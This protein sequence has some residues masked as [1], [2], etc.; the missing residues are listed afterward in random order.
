[1]PTPPKK[2][3]SKDKF[4]SR[5]ISYIVKKEGKPQKQAIAI[6]NSMWRRRKMNENEDNEEYKEFT[7]ICPITTYHAVKPIKQENNED[8]KKVIYKESDETRHAVA[9][10]GDRFY[11]GKFL[12]AKELEKVYPKWKG[13]LHDINHMGTTHLMGLGVVSDIR[14]FVGYQKNVTYD[15]KTKKV[16][17]DIKGNEKTLYGKAWRGYVNLCEEAGKIPNVSIA[18]QGKLGTMKAKDLPED[19]NYSD[20][21]LKEDDIIEYIYDI[22]PQA[23]STVH[24]GAC[25]D[26]DGCG[27]GIKNCETDKCDL[28]DEDYEKRRQELIKKLIEEEKKDE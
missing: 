1:M 24:S 2:G 18:F 16:S 12:P 11:K 15:S 22:R 27:I 19:V 9:I 21:G 4:I 7:F 13:T 26:E 3:E 17:M 5:C 10:I 8:N 23:L 20:Y 6:C 14:F 28:S 25:N